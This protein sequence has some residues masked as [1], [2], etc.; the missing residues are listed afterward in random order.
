MIRAGS[1]QGVDRLAP[2]NP[3]S[4][5]TRTRMLPPSTR[6]Q[7]PFRCWQERTSS[8]TS[9]DNSRVVVRVKDHRRRLLSGI[10]EVV[11]KLILGPRPRMHYGLEALR[12]RLDHVVGVA[13]GE[14][15]R[16]ARPHL[17]PPQRKLRSSTWPYRYTFRLIERVQGGSGTQPCT[18]LGSSPAMCSSYPRQ[19]RHHLHRERQVL[20]RVDVAGHT[21]RLFPFRSLN[22][23]GLH[24]CRCRSSEPA[25]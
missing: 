2:T 17:L 7:H 22:A 24:Q 25:S 18:S 14:T 16:E 11:R 10:E 3:L 5:V 12:H 15:G 8:R 23:N 6:G 19:A 21:H 20:L 1:P 9:R 13:L 4:P